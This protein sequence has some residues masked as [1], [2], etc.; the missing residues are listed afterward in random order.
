[1][2]EISPDDSERLNELASALRAE[3]E[4]DQSERVKRAAIH[5]IEELKEDALEALK[6]TIRHSANEGLRAR[7]SMW[8][9]DRIIDAQSR[10][11]DDLKSLLQGMPQKDN[12][13]DSAD[14]PAAT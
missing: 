12:K 6:Q 8:A 5:D 2:S 14:S 9:Y 1:M 3:F 10:S 4:I 7:V 11:E 13:Q